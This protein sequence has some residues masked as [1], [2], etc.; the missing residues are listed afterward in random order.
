MYRLRSAVLL[1]LMSAMAGAGAPA[2]AADVCQ[3]AQGCPRS[4][5]RECGFSPYTGE[6][7]CQ[8]KPAPFSGACGCTIQGNPVYACG[9][10]GECVYINEPCEKA[11]HNSCHYAPPEPPTHR[12]LTLASARVLGP[13]RTVISFPV[14]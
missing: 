5:C 8:Q 3:A 12:V 1:L 13:A 11:F 9:E 4:R 14:S 6:F 7:G 10:V 2:A